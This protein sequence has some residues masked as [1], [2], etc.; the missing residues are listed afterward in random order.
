M[1][2][3][4]RE[5]RSFSTSGRGD[6]LLNLALQVSIA[7]VPRLENFLMKILF[8]DIIIIVVL[9]TFIDLIG[10]FIWR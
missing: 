6:S 9:L 1:G 4:P 2:T 5:K 10:Y 7:S 3:P 8:I